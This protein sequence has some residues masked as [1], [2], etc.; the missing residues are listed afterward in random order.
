MRILLESRKQEIFHCVV[1][2]LHSSSNTQHSP[3]HPTPQGVHF[4]SNQPY[5]AQA[6]Q[7]RIPELESQLAQLPG[8]VDDEQRMALA[9]EELSTYNSTCGIVGVT[10]ESASGVVESVELLFPGVKL[11]TLEQIIENSF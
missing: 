7:T 2:Q 3:N 11:A 5:R 6:F 10:S 8:Q 4:S 1:L 9:T